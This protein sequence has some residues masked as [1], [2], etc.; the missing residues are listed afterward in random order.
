M[1]KCSCGP[2]IHCGDNYCADCG[3][4]V[5]FFFYVCSC[6]HKQ[7]GGNRYCVKCGE[8]T[9]FGTMTSFM[10]EIFISKSP[11]LIEKKMFFGKDGLFSRQ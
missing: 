1:E 7:D 6:G 10:R 4:A 3:K 11:Y 9:T 5:Q 2:A 8:I